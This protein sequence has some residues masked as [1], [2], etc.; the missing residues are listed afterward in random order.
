LFGFFL[1]ILSACQGSPEAAPAQKKPL[2]D[3]RGII[4]CHSKYSH[5]SQGTYEEIL[6]AA[7]AAK[8]DF[9]CMTDHPP[10]G[11]PGLSLREGWTG[12]HDGVLFI[13]G[14]EFGEQIL[15]LGLK[16]PIKGKDRREKIREIHAQGG[17]AIACHPELIEDWEEY[18]EADGMEIFN[19]HATFQRKAKEKKFL[20]QVPKVMKEKPEE[21][22]QLLQ[23]LDPAILKKY[24]EI[25]GKRVFAGIAGNDSH[26][27]VSF[28][29]YQLDPYPRAFKFVTTHVLAEELTQESVLDALRKG[30]AYVK[31]EISSR[32]DLKP[33]GLT[34]IGE[35]LRPD[36]RV[37]GVES[38]LFISDS[39]ARWF[40][41]GEPFRPPT[42]GS[43]SRRPAGIELYSLEAPGAYRVELRTF[44]K[45]PVG[46]EPWVLT[47]PVFVRP[48][49][50]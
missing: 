42:L 2:R 40:K 1:L 18:A 3:F 47:N 41:D 37:V 17:L 19:V 24:D 6:A 10:K 45:D 27:N 23:E 49:P 4:H 31:F 48:G 50:P 43:A 8:I 11:D 5:D 32:Q 29:G 14:A 25:S 9:I 16:E 20:L 35:Q 15:G 36:F 26:Q 21:C 12:I 44:S 22:F 13:Q 46:G 28:F 39:T 33:E 7:Q 34:W 38:G 30:R